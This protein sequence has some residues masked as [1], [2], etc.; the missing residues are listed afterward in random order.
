MKEL[1]V[2][3]NEVT[4]AYSTYSTVA[5]QLQMAQ[6]KVLEATPVYT[7]VESAYVPITAKSPR[8]MIIMVIFVFFACVLATLRL[9]YVIVKQ[10]KW[11]G[12]A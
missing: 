12:K 6:A 5:S 2:L 7:V 3:E 4:L 8:K 11:K 1:T 9:A 10:K